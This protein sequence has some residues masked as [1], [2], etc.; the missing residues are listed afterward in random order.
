MKDI[1]RHIY[2]TWCDRLYPQ[3]KAG[4]EYRIDYGIC[5]ECEEETQ[6]RVRK[7]NDKR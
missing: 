3:P 7:K 1:S 4:Q 2:C 6:E 5:K